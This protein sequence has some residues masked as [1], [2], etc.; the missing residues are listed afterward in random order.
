MYRGL[1]SPG[2]LAE[3][4]S[5]VGIR[6]INPDID[7][8]QGTPI[9]T[10]CRIIKYNRKNGIAENGIGQ[11]QDKVLT[12]FATSYL[13]SV[14]PSLREISQISSIPFHECNDLFGIEKEYK[15]L[16]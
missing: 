5:L 7:N 11:S 4:T 3:T 8:L 10:L 16:K 13:E 12:Q 2:R 15:V 14:E 6:S 9:N 1:Q